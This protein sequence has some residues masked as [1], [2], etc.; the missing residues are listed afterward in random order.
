MGQQ[1]SHG[2][3]KD[4]G[5]VGGLF[6]RPGEHLAGPLPAL[7]PTHLWERTSPPTTDGQLMLW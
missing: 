2:C 4:G 3:M 7:D 1:H 6:P 5:M